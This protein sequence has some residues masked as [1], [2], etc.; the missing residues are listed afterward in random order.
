[1]I[2]RRVPNTTVPLEVEGGGMRAF[3]RDNGLTLFFLTALAL[4]LV[5]QALSGPA[6]HNEKQVAQGAPESGLGDYLTGSEFAVDVTENWQSEYLQFFLYIFVTVWL[7]QRGCRE[8]F[9]TAGR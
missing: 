2:L 6:V 7:I 8:P 9:D 4:A 1:M 3:L 5:G